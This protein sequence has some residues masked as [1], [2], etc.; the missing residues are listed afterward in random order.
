M[1][2]TTTDILIGI[3]GVI[4]IVALF[5]SVV[6]YISVQDTNELDTI[7]TEIL[8]N[9]VLILDLQNDMDDLDFAKESYIDNKLDTITDDIEDLEHDVKYL[10]NNVE[11]DLD[12]L[13]DCI[14]NDTTWTNIKNCINDL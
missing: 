9:N 12:E 10:N 14:E 6:G 7:K 11:D 2:E 8:A 1:D 4:S 3:F 5:L 13:L